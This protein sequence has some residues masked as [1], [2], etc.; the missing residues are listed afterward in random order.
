MI[1]SNYPNPKLGEKLTFFID[2]QSMRNNHENEDCRACAVAFID[3]YEKLRN[4]KS[5]SVSFSST[6]NKSFSVAKIKETLPVFKKSDCKT[7]F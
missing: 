5:I 7:G 4:A 3:F 6:V 1:N 2:G